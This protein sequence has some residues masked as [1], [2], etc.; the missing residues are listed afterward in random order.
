MNYYKVTLRITDNAGFVKDVLMSFLGDAGFDSFEETAQGFNAY[1][2][3]N[4]YNHTTLLSIINDAIASYDCQI[5][6]RE[7]F[8]KEQNWNVVWEQNSF[9]PIEIDNRLVI[10]PSLRKNDYI[11]SSFNFK[12]ELNPVQAFGS[13]YHETTRMMLSF[14]MEENMENKAFLDMGCG[15]AVLAILARMRH[16]HP[17]VAIDIDHWSTENA[18][19]NAKLN[20]T[21]DIQVVLGDAN[22]IKPLRIGFD[23][24]FANINRNILIQ[25]MTHYLS[26][27]SKGGSLFV[28]GFYTE[29]FDIVRKAAEDEGLH[30]VSHKTDSNWVAAKFTL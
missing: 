3:E 16:A 26:A 29:D 18:V 5:A 17:V 27:L 9:E 12:I 6:Y 15:T 1:V 8:V 21:T 19:E 28:S 10:Y 23:Y 22:A 20:N 4:L 25:D 24:I 13:G 30:Y 11:E 14:I 2:P 7:E